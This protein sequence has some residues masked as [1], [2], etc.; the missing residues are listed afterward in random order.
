DAWGLARPDKAEGI[1]R[2]MN[3]RLESEP[4]TKFV[5]SDINFITLGAIVEKVSGERLD[6]YA[7]TH[8]FG[9]LRMEET[10]FLPPHYCSC[11]DPETPAYGS[12][13]WGKPQVIPRKCFRNVCGPRLMSE[14]SRIAPT[15]HDNEGTE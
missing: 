9:P 13:E 11:S 3:A 12:P 15:Q 5:Y 8:I 6:E 4:G 7:H 2:A 10:S 14:M 1:M